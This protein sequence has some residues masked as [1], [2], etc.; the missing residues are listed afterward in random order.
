VPTGG[1][2]PGILEQAWERT[3]AALRDS[4]TGERPLLA[5]LPARDEAALERLLLVEQMLWQCVNRERYLVYQRAWKEFYRAWQRDRIGEW[6]T[7]EPFVHQHRRVCEAARQHGL[8]PAPLATEAAKREIYD[9]GRHRA[10]ALVAA[11]SDELALV[12]VPLDTMLP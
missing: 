8:P 2:Q 7:V 5:A 9:R 12:A 1:F 11:T 4:F 3:P 10:T 6:P